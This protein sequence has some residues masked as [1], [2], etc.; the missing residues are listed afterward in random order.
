M[1]EQ[2]MKTYEVYYTITF[3]DHQHKCDGL[4]E[5]NSTDVLATD[6]GRVRSVSSYDD[7]VDYV[8]NIYNHFG[9]EHLVEIPLWISQHSDGL[10]DTMFDLE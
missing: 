3:V 5:V 9:E 2:N 7:A 6:D 10:G 8:Y 1:K 4:L